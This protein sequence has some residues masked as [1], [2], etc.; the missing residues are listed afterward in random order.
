MQEGYLSLG[1]QGAAAVQREMFENSE[2]VLVMAD[3]RKLGKHALYKSL[4]IEKIQV[5]VTNQSQENEPILES[6]RS[7]G[8]RVILAKRPEV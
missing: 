6:I 7:K 8:V 4:P 3:A 2:R 1:P 5:L